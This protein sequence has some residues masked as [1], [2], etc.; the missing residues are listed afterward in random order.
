[1]HAVADAHDTPFNKVNVAPAGLGMDCTA[2]L[3]PFQ[4]SAK[5]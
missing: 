5:P 2:Q 4:R 3:V 1:V